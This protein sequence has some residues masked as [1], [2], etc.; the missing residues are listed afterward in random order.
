MAVFAGGEVLV[1]Q[2]NDLEAETHKR[3]QGWALAHTAWPTPMSPLGVFTQGVE[4]ALH[5]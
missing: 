5:L 2:P 3:E 4:T 1:S